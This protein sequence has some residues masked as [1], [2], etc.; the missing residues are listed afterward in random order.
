MAK[1]KPYL[2]ANFIPTNT[3][4]FRDVESVYPDLLAAK[5]IN[6]RDSI[7]TY[8]IAIITSVEEN[9]SDIISKK[10][11]GTEELWW[12]ICQFNGVVNPL[13]DLYVGL[14]IKIPKYQELIIYLQNSVNKTNSRIG[15]ITVI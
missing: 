2:R 8:S 10:Y 5:Y 14:E 6:L 11:Y 7:K 4:A 1:T 3:S 13:E 15:T 9:R 12:I